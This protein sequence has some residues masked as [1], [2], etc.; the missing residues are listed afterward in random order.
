MLLLS[1]CFVAEIGKGRLSLLCLTCYLPFEQHGKQD[2]EWETDTAT[3]GFI[4]MPTR[5][6]IK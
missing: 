2:W 5:Q 4:L 3:V 6:S 1:G